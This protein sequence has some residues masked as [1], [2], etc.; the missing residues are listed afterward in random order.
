MPKRRDDLFKRLTQLF[1]GGPSIRRKVKAFR[2]PS[3]STAVEVFKKSYSQV[4][5]NALNAYGSYDRMSCS[6]LTRV[7]IPGPEGFK[8]LQELAEL[9]PDGEQF[10]VYAFDH[11]RG[12]LVP[13]WAHHSRC[14]DIKPTVK[15][16]FDDSSTL[17]CT[18][19]HEC[20][21]RDGTYRDAGDLKPGDNM[22]P[23]Y[24][25]Q[26]NGTSKEDGKKFHGYRSV[27]TMGREEG[28]WRGW[29]S[30]HR[31]VAEWFHDRKLKKG[32][33]HIHHIDHDP[34][35]NNPENL[36]FVD[37]KEH[38]PLSG[39]ACMHLAEHVIYE[40]EADSYEQLQQ[41][42]S[43]HI[44]VSVEPWET[45]PVGDLTVDGYENFATDTIITHNSRYA[46]FAEMTYCLAG[47]TKI[48]VPGGYKTLEE[49]SSQHGFDEEFYVYAYDHEKQQIV[50]AMGKQARQTMVTDAWKVTFDSGKSITGS[51]NHRLMLRDG[52]YRRIDEL[53]EGD[54]M[55]P[56]YRRD[57]YKNLQE[58]EEKDSGDGYRWVYVTNPNVGRNG[59][60]SEHRLVAAWAADRELKS[61]EVVHHINF[62]KHDN[63]PENL[64]IMDEQDHLSYHARLN[65]E[66]K[67]NKENAEWIENFKKRQSEFMKRN[68][69]TARP[70]ITF[71]R[72]LETCEA[73]DFNSVSVA[74]AL[75]TS[76]NLVKDRLREAGFENFETFARAYRPG[77]RNAGWDN[78][79]KK[80]PRYDASLTF[81][82][83]SDAYES[84]MQLKELCRKLGTT[85]TK[86]M[87]RLRTEGYAYFRQFQESFS[88]HK[89]ISIE[90]VGVIP[91]YDLTVDG[92]KNFATDSVMSHNTPEVNSALEIYAEETCA[93]DDK[94]KSLHIYSDNPKIHELV[95]TLMYDTLNLEH[96]L[97]AWTQNLLKYGDLFLFLDIHPEMGV[98]NAFPMPVNEVERDEGWDPEDPLAVRFRWTQQGNQILEAWQVAHFRLMGNDAFLPYGSSILESARR[99]WRQLILIEDAMLVYRVVRSPERRVFYIDVGTVPTEE[100]PNYMEAAQSKLKR[101]QVIDKSSGRVDLRY[102]PLPISKQ[103][104]IPLLDGRTITIEQLANEY[105]LGK[106]NWVYSVQDGT[107]KVVPGKVVWCGKNYTAERLTR[108]WLDDGSYVDAAPEHPFMMRDGS[109]R[110]A[111]GLQP[112]DSLMP[113]YRRLSSKEKGDYNAGYEVVYQPG[114]NDWVQTHKAVSS[115]DCVDMGRQI[116][117]G[118][119]IH[120]MNHR[121]WDNRPVNLQRMGWFEHKNHHAE[122]NRSPEHRE[123][124][125]LYNRKHQKAQ[126]MGAAYNGSELHKEHNAIR[127]VSMT[128]FW[129]DDARSEKAK[130]NMCWVIPD[131]VRD[132]VFEHIRSNPGL[133]RARATQWLRSNDALLH[134]MKAANSGNN[135]DIDKLHIDAFANAAC[136]TGFIGRARYIV[137][138]NTLCEAPKNHSV[139]RIETVECLDDVYCMTVVGPDGQHDRH[140]FALLSEGGDGFSSLEDAVCAPVRLDERGC[141]NTPQLRGGI[142]MFQ[143]VDEDYFIPIRG[144]ESGTKIDTLAGGTH[145]SDIADVEYIQRKLFA[146][147][148]V[149]KSYLGYDESLSSKATLAQL[150]IRFSRSIARIQKA[151]ISELE[152]VAIIHLFAHGYEGEDLVDFKLKLSNPSSVAQLQKLELWRT[153]FEIAGSVPEGL[154]DRAFIRR[155]LFELSDEQIEDIEEGLRHDH[156][157]DLTLEQEADEFGGGGGGGGL[158]GLGGDDPF[159][160][161]DDAFGDGAGG[162]AGDAAGAGGSEASGDDASGDEDAGGDEDLFAGDDPA[163]DADTDDDG[164]R[165]LTSDDDALDEDEDDGSEG[166]G[167]D[168]HGPR[169]GAAGTAIARTLSRLNRN[170]RRA[171]HGKDARGSG[172]ARTTPLAKALYNRGR[173]RT[174]G[175]RKTH[176]PDFPAMVAPD[177]DVYDDRFFKGSPFKEE[178]SLLPLVDAAPLGRDGQGARLSAEMKS[179]LASLQRRLDSVRRHDSVDILTEAAEAAD[180]MLGVHDAFEDAIVEL[181]LGAIDVDAIETA[182]LDESPTLEYEDIDDGD[183]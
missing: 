132:I 42:I 39:R 123:M 105:D 47:D 11:A 64:L 162:V 178:R 156:I 30:E 101:S 48:A 51:A 128:K 119:V 130:K 167:S 37:A 98:V 70:D 155:E 91:L 53:H 129:S 138:R 12:R 52:T 115:D 33:E 57:F 67:W 150:D 78:R 19:D 154:V 183:E 43:N 127:S 17:V 54:S 46:D 38:A 13:A 97:I 175:P 21:L 111:D 161:G 116:D 14:T 112:E 173:R 168:Q 165:L 76:Q 152:K 106:E 166:E 18:S 71:G 90:H 8:T 181:D 107:Y 144:S 136:R 41:T 117:E 157:V 160:G 83:I 20:M 80:N 68:N 34:E 28:T 100:I 109:R 182:G 124:V 87:N 27:Y 63:R 85:R 133:S 125:A 81:K 141:M 171:S 69:P 2:T 180:D 139:S 74:D 108:V 147:L 120:H 149:P 142:F 49:L 146:A 62:V 176:M 148:K 36:E 10:I 65:N 7:A 103:S 170:Q 24:R 118:V 113:F 56:F 50:P 35:N 122:A 143:S 44:V 73:L 174:H 110:R 59:W 72:I 15:L 126:K 29:T 16:T 131:D 92:Y 135:R 177:Y 102:N 99:I 23:F 151:V 45:L 31:M 84:K 1:K 3:A 4:Y 134:K 164:Q 172:P 121:K 32:E 25:R 5:S 159:G 61:N 82:S 66:K 77:W 55:M 104:L 153:K 58:G 93:S 26:F 6:M 89:V 9:Y 60:V 40:Q 179:V 88:N 22:M 79:G 145:V 137:L 169:V 158:G 75:D 114:P 140:N 163:D 96:N 95:E 86:V 94:S